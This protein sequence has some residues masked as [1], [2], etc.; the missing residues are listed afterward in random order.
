MA[1]QLAMLAKFNPAAARNQIE[2][3]LAR[4]RGKRAPINEASKLLKCS[5]ITLW[6]VMSLIGMRSSRVKKKS[7][8]KSARVGSKARNKKRQRAA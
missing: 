5:R 3:T 2:R 7:A 1:T 8:A 6:K 4:V